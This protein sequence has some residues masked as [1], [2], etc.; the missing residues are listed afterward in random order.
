M[1]QEHSP[2]MLQPLDP[3]KLLEERGEERLPVK[4]GD[5]Y[6]PSFISNQLRNVDAFL[7][8]AGDHLGDVIQ[9][10]DRCSAKPLLKQPEAPVRGKLRMPYHHK[11]ELHRLM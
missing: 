10:G 5:D 6:V 11:V 1:T 2:E 8:T 4:L 3:L 7:S 9:T